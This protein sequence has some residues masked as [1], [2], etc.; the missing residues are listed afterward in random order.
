MRRAPC[1]EHFH[2][3]NLPLHHFIVDEPSATDTVCSFFYYRNYRTDRVT[4]FGVADFHLL[5][6]AC[7]G[8]IDSVEPSG[9]V[10]AKAYTLVLLRAVIRN[11][12]LQII[13]LHP[14]SGSISV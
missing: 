5:G 3:R 14:K 9:K 8:H 7:T 2:P 4:S 11:D 12:P 10:V 6:L 13:V 1:L